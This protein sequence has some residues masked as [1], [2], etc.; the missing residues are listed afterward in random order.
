MRK[1]IM[2]LALLG[3]LIVAAGIPFAAPAVGESPNLNPKI[4]P[5]NSMPYGMSYG[6][7][8]GA[9]WR[10][11]YSIPA[12]VNPVQDQT[13][14]NAAIGQSGPVF[15]LA[16]TFGGPAERTVTVPAGKALFFPILNYVWINVPELGDNPWS[17]EQE[18]FARAL[19]AG[20]MDLATNMTCQIDGRPVLNIDAYRCETPPGED[21]MVT[22]PDFS[23][24]W[25][26]LPAG[27]YGP[28]VDTGY[29]LMLAPLAA[30]KHTIHF[31]GELTTDPPFSLEVTYHLTVSGK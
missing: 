24:A 10:W 11:C 20:I 15:F 6:A 4:L 26:I 18:A 8:A 21:Y 22:L 1:S 28:C 29:Y 7:W 12:A 13:G 17:P 14:E 23:N 27:T 3:A 25:P 31:T 16:G 19:V 9:W 5:I 30:G 2:L